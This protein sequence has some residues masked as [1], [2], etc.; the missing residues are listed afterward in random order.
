MSSPRHL[1]H[2]VILSRRDLF[3]LDLTVD[4][5][6]KQITKA[7]NACVLGRAWFA[8]HTIQEGPAAM[9]DGQEVSIEDAI[10]EAAQVVSL[11]P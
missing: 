3:H 5:D 11:R 7:K 8:E 4:L 9:I 10:E 6:K 2:D 1:S